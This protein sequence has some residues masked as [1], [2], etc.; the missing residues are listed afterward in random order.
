[1]ARWETGTEES[2]RDSAAAAQTEKEQQQEEEQLKRPCLNKAEGKNIFLKCP[3][4]STHTMAHAH[5]MH[6]CTH[7]DFLSTHK[8]NSCVTRLPHILHLL[9]S[10]HSLRDVLPDPWRGDVGVPFIYDWLCIRQ[11]LSSVWP[12]VNLYSYCW[13]LK[14]NHLWPKLVRAIKHWHK[15][16]A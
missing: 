16:N 14:R 7:T 1:M 15:H 12:V 2:P 11:L 4:T 9:R 13:P 10:F 3:L 5:N 8:Y 6:T